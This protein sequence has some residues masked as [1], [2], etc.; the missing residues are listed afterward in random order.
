MFN[1][2]KLIKKQDQKAT[3][4]EEETVKVLQHFEQQAADYIQ[5]HLRFVFVNSAEQNSFTNAAGHEGKYILIRVPF[6]SL[7]SLRKVS[8]KVIDHLES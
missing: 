6:R 1:T 2:S 5:K 8:S 4:L 7:A 3:E